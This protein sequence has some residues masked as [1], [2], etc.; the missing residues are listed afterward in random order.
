HGALYHASAEQPALAD[1][2]VGAAAAALGTAVVVVGPGRGELVA[3][4]A[5]AGIEYAREGFADRETRADGSLVP[6]S[7]AG[8]VLVDP[9]ACAARARSLALR[10]DIETVCVHGDTPGAVSIARAVR[11]A[12]DVLA[13]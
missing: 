6:R 1:A 8:A 9:T 13:E 7:E 5:R 2:V 3:A 12:L 4:A 11:A 10:G